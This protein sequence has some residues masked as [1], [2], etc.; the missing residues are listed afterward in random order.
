MYLYRYQGMIPGI[1]ALKIGVC[2]HRAAMLLFRPLSCAP[3]AP[4]SSTDPV[5][6]PRY[7][8]IPLLATVFFQNVQVERV[9]G[10]DIHPSVA[11]REERPFT[12]TPRLPLLIVRALHCSRHTRVALRASLCRIIPAYKYQGLEWASPPQWRIG[13]I[14]NLAV[15]PIELRNVCYEVQV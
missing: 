8:N 11:R 9:Q 15:R 7:K 5:A 4:W 12:Q 1:L 14:L 2:S 3:P 10:E 6:T 13:H